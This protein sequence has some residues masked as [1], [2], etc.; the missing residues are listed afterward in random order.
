MRRALAALLVAVQA[1]LYA[2]G[3]IAAWPAR[4][5]PSSNFAPRFPSSCSRVPTGTKC[6]EAG[7]RY[8][9]SA[10]ARLHQPPYKLPGNFV[11]LAPDQ[12]VLILT[13]LDRAVYH[14]SPIA[15]LTNELN[16]DALAGV[17]A[18][19]D[20]QPGVRGFFNDP[21][22]QY[23]GSNWAYAYPNIVFAYGAW[24]YDDGLG[25][26]NGDCTLKAKQ[27]CWGHRHNVLLELPKEFSLGGPTAMGVAAGK[28]RGGQ[29]GY[30]MVLGRGDAG[31]TPKYLYE[32]SDHTNR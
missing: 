30:A 14:L 11:K 16:G 18:D 3:A 26:P 1:G 8:L 32:S 9:N 2:S 31:Y 21:H 19:N 22:F 5:D 28:D 23:F 25:S 24:I 4:S 17:R 13:N 20:P 6:L 15:G 10:R 29:L 7:L 27:G 12:Q